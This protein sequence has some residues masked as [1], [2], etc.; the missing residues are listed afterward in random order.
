MTAGSAAVGEISSMPHSTEP[1]TL[2]RVCELSCPQTRAGRG[3]SVK[4]LNLMDY[5]GATGCSLKKIPIMEPDLSLI[6]T[7]LYTVLYTGNLLASYPL[8]TI[9]TTTLGID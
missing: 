2:L 5:S 7:G 9:Y 1:S 6:D 4:P 3:S 8:H